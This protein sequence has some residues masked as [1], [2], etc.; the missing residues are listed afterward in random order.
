MWEDGGIRVE[1]ARSGHLRLCHEGGEAVVLWLWAEISGLPSGARLF[2]QGRIGE[3]E[4]FAVEGD[5]T[6]TVEAAW[7]DVSGLPE[8]TRRR[9]DRR[10]GRMRG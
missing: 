2:L 9:G 10:A 3:L 6:G 5:A 4:A 1:L 7:R 8:R